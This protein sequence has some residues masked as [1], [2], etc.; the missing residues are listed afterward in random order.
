MLPRREREDHHPG[1]EGKFSMRF[2]RNDSEVITIV[3]GTPREALREEAIILLG[4]LGDS[5]DRDDPGIAQLVQEGFSA[6]KVV[7]P[8][9][10][11]TPRWPTRR[12]SEVVER[13]TQ[14]VWKAKDILYPGHDQRVIFYGPSMGGRIAL[15][16][17][18]ERP[19]E[20]AG[21]V[22]FNPA[23]C[24]PGA[25]FL[26]RMGR[27]FSDGV[28]GYFKGDREQKKSSLGVLGRLVSAPIASLHLGASSLKQDLP[29]IAADL[30]RK[31]VKTIFVLGTGDTIF[32]PKETKIGFLDEIFTDYAKAC[33]QGNAPHGNFTTVVHEF[34]EADEGHYIRNYI[35]LGLRGTRR[36]IRGGKPRIR[37]KKGSV[38]PSQ[39]EASE[40]ELF[41]P[42][43]EGTLGDH[44]VDDILG[45]DV[46]V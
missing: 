37:Q 22:L 31:E 44:R 2:A 10:D 39:Q 11:G 24:P 35:D 40:Q 20:T 21:V 27:Y 23:Y 26:N 46:V 30:A 45:D 41:N 29:K 1:Q 7:G 6:A 16:A 8:H 17:A 5:A 36:L 33:K 19:E 12:A 42:A 14:A 28:T 4:G 18:S 15:L 13:A 3:H 32:D 34:I 9:G 25:N 43:G 38:F